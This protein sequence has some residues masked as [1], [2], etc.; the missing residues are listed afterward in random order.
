MHPVSRWGNADVSAVQLQV[1]AFV[2]DPQ[3]VSDLFNEVGSRYSD[4][5]SGY[6]RVIKDD[7]PRRGDGAPMA[8]IELV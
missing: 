1:L 3:L 2:Y 6:C 8:I 7:K 5:N 4:R